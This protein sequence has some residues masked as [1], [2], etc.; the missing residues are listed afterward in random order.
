[1]VETPSEKTIVAVFG[2]TEVVSTGTVEV[3]DEAL[4]RS[5]YLS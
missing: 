4:P 2:T 3:V 1:M 5:R